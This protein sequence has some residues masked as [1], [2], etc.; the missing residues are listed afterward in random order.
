[1]ANILDTIA[2]ST[3]KRV[4]DAKEHFLREKQTTSR[5]LGNEQDGYSL[6]LLVLEG[7]ETIFGVTLSV[8]SKEA[9]LKMRSRWAAESG[10]L[11]DLIWD[12]LYRNQSEESRT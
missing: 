2:E 3:R 7:E 12:R 1:M 4:A 6:E 8:A 11:Y 9:A 10:A 5:L